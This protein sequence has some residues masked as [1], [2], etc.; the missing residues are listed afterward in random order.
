MREWKDG[1]DYEHKD[2]LV[3]SVVA[4]LEKRERPSLPSRF[5]DMCSSALLPDVNPA[6]VVVSIAADPEIIDAVRIIARDMEDA[7]EMA[8]KAKQVVRD[9]DVIEHFTK[10]TEKEQQAVVAYI[11]N[12]D[13]KLLSVTRKHSGLHSAPGG[14]VEPGETKIEALYREVL[15]ETGVSIIGWRLVYEGLHD[16]GRRVFAYLVEEDWF[17]G[18]PVAR[19]PGTKVEWVDPEVIANG[20]ASE[21]HRKALQAAGIL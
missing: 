9:F 19:E 4:I 3:A 10:P 21:Y 2:A 8:A 7:N 13:G 17:T 16:S 14:K 20:F 5:Y 6:E 18:E 11:Q 1:A 15:E 12:A